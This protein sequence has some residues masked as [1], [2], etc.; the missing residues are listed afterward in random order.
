MSNK[1]LDASG[2]S[3][4]VIDNLTVAWLT[5]AASTQAF[6]GFTLYEP[7]SHTPRFIGVDHCG[8]A[9]VHIVFVY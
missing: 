3:G 4:F 5:P 6:G 1:S 7:I 8:C 9:S 2:T